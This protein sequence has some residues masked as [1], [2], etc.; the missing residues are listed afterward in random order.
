MGVNS[1]PSGCEKQM[2]LLGFICSRKRNNFSINAGRRI[3][4][5]A[6]MMKAI[7]LPRFSKISIALYHENQSSKASKMPWLIF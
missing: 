3:Q 5:Q 1:E 7:P 2:P 6:V 4:D